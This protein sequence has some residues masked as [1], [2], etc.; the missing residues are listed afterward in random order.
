MFFY[1]DLYCKWW[2]SL[3]KLKKTFTSQGI[4]KIQVIKYE[5]LHGANQ[6]FGSGRSWC[7]RKSKVSLELL[8]SSCYYII[9]FR[10]FRKS[11]LVWNPSFFTCVLFS[12]F[13]FGKGR[14]GKI[15][16]FLSI[17]SKFFFRSCQNE[18]QKQAISNLH[19]WCSCFRW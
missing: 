5:I 4:D 16:T 15:E 11:A 12:S 1:R 18:T 10:T 13:I 2:R 19:S 14:E 9:S 3:G 8:I 17:F 6:W 7:T